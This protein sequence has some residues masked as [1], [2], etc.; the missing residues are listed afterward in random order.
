[1][2]C[3]GHS[4]SQQRLTSGIHAIGYDYDAGLESGPEG[5]R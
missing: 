3:N 5:G 1:M 2:L 4:A